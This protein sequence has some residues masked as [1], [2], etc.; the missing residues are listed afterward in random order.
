ML[1]NVAEDACFTVSVPDFPRT[2]ES[3]LTH[4]IVITRTLYIEEEDFR[5]V[6]DKDYFGLAPGKTAGLRYAGFLKV[7]GYSVDEGSGR[8]TEV[9]AEYD[10]DRVVLGK[11]GKVKGN[12]HFVSGSAPTVE[13]RLYE[14]LFTTEVP[15]ST[16]DWEKELA[17]VS[18][19]VLPGARAT[20]SLLA[21]GAV[22]VGDHFQFERVG[23]F[24]LDSDADVGAGKLVFNMTVGLKE[25]AEVKKVKGPAAKA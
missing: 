17:P 18:E 6:D 14:H 2:P 20:P 1:T 21:P 23:Y 24:I 19:R 16:G 22:S 10:H 4:P 13:V 9:Q 12:L 11:E 7:N 8:V 25:A 3:S 15:G 5:V